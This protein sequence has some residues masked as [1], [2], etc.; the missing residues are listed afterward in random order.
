MKRDGKYLP[1]GVVTGPMLAITGNDSGPEFILSQ[2]LVDKLMAYKDEDV[3]L[4]DAFL[5]NIMV[6]LHPKF[7]P[8]HD[9]SKANPIAIIGDDGRTEF[10]DFKQ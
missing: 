2:E 9:A 8:G 1:G 4:P 3:I 10:A 5:K 7:L 6:R